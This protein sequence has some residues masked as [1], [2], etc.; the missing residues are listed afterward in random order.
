MPA[1]TANRSIHSSMFRRSFNLCN[2]L[3]Q[4]LILATVA[5]AR[6]KCAAGY[7]AITENHSCGDKRKVRLVAVVCVLLYIVA[8]GRSIRCS[9]GR[10]ARALG[11]RKLL[12]QGSKK[13]ACIRFNFDQ[14]PFFMIINVLAQPVIHLRLNGMGLLRREP[15]L[16]FFLKFLPAL[17]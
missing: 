16:Q 1:T 9:P 15:A 2:G 10:A 4:R 6:D 14:V 13:C 11:L 7:A 8:V 17:Q 12:V 3:P 5:N